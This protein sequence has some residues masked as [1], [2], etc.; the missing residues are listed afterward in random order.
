[1]PG[2]DGFGLR[3]EMQRRCEFEDIPVIISTSHAD[4]QTVEQA[5]IL[6]CQHYILKPPSE[7]PLL[8]RISAA[9]RKHGLIL[10]DKEVIIRRSGLTSEI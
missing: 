3:K 8:Q 1:M 9:T 7:K 10:E 6:G 5:K 4:P 2:M